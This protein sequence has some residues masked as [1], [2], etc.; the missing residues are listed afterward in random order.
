[1]KIAYY[2][3]HVFQELPPSDTVLS[4]LERTSAT[5]ITR[6]QVLNLAGSFL[7]SGDDVHKPIGV[8]SGGERARVCLARMLLSKS[9][10]LLLDEPTNH[11]DFETVEGLGR[12]LHSFPGTVFFV[13]HDR[14][15]V[16]MVATNI[17]QVKDGSIA[18]Y[19]G[20]Y[21]EYVHH[22]EAALE[23]DK[24]TDDV[25]QT[26]AASGKEKN[27]ANKNRYKLKKELQSKRNKVSKI[28]NKLE[29]E[30]EVL[31]SERQEILDFFM[32]DSAAY[33]REQN[34][35]LE[36]LTSIIETQEVDWLEKQEELEELNRQF[37]ELG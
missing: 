14:T 12:A 10:I 23:L 20:T 27:T 3:Q 22:L 33:C 8:L 1:L 13:S 35:R 2:A 4:Y 28:V 31:Q 29:T 26:E 16:Q 17:L 30:L 6:Q 34:E 19:N 25:P 9:D 18:L 15:F 24:P 11:L 21:P 36:E 5:E 37:E 7:F 32:S